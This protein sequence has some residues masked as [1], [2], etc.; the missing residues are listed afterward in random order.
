MLS[1]RFVVVVDDDDDDDDRIY[2]MESLIY[3]NTKTL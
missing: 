2:V 1:V 3:P